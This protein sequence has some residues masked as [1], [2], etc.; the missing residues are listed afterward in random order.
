MKTGCTVSFEMKKYVQLITWFFFSVNV[1]LVWFFKCRTEM[2]ANSVVSLIGFYPNQ[3]ERIIQTPFFLD[4]GMAGPRQHVRIL[5]P[6][7][8]SKTFLPPSATNTSIVLP[9]ID[10]AYISK[11][12]YVKP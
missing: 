4:L 9:L 7:V 12:M 3:T 2:K 6:K 11:I 1:R 10:L 5:Y 8:D